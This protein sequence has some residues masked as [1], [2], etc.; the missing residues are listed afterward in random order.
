MSKLDRVPLPRANKILRLLYASLTLSV[1]TLA[2]SAIYRGYSSF[3]LSRFVSGVT[4][5]FTLAF[6]V[7]THRALSKKSDVAD[8]TDVVTTEKLLAISRIPHIILTFILSLM[9]LA[10]G[11]LEA[12][13]VGYTFRTLS[14]L[15]PTTTVQEVFIAAHQR[16]G[17]S[18]FVP[19]L[20]LMYVPFP[21]EMVANVQSR[22]GLPADTLASMD[23]RDEAMLMEWLRNSLKP[24]AAVT[25]VE[26][27]VVL[28]QLGVLLAIGIMAIMERR[29]VRRAAKLG[30]ISI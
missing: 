10:T 17:L 5:V 30:A 29:E 9:W 8:S 11:L 12:F 24:F 7:L 15:K 27:V 6:T 26:T 2:I 21:A 16:P 20:A 14:E 25:A 22:T 19:V 1:T 28:A 4:F 13:V 3:G 23:P 18:I